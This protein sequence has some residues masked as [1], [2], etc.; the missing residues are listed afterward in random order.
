MKRGDIVIW[1]IEGQANSFEL[2]AEISADINYT[3][4]LTGDILTDWGADGPAGSDAVMWDDVETGGFVN[5]AFGILVPE[6]VD[7][8]FTGQYTYEADISKLSLGDT[9]EDTF[10]Y[11]LTDAD[12]DTAQATLTVNTYG[13][14]AVDS[15]EV[16]TPS[17]E[18]LSGGSG[19]DVIVG[20][21]GSD[22]MSGGG[23]SDIFAYS[24]ADLDGST[25]VISDFE[26]G[27]DG[28]ILDLS[29]IF[30]ETGIEDVQDL[31][32]QDYLTIQ[33]AGNQLSVKVDADGDESTISDIVNVDITVSGTPDPGD[34]ALQTMLDND[35]IKIG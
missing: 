14:G 24:P 32:D 18:S 17:D 9:G 3:P 1:T 22:T 8:Q 21:P 25:D 15:L 20:G 29:A 10:T 31:I 4:T 6:V 34:T 27:Q 7:G 11:T 19:N 16:G 35:Q 26:L 23:G 30:A 33:E 5:G 2:I 12:G 13:M 28:D